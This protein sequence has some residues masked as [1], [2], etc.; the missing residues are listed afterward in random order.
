MADAQIAVVERILMS[1]DKGDSVAYTFSTRDGDID[2]TSYVTKHNGGGSHQLAG[3]TIQLAKPHMP[4][5]LF[6]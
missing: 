5:F 2:V 6:N 3:V 4:Y 1:D